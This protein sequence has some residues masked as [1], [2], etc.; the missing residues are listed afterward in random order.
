M[1]K[2]YDLIS[3]PKPNN[4]SVQLIE[5]PPK[6]YA[7]IVFSGLVRE[8][9]Y[10]EKANLLNQFLIDQSLQALGPVKIA[11][12]NPPWTLPFFR[13]NELMVEIN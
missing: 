9:S 1:P 8:S 4:P 5:V 7:V 11:R 3:L 13:R 2:E 6:K 12:H 10:E